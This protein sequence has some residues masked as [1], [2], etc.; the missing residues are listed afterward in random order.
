MKVCSKC[1]KELS[2][3]EFHKNKYSKDGHRSDCKS[4]H[5]Q[6]QR[7][8]YYKAKERNNMDYSKYKKLLFKQAWYYSRK[9]NLDF[10]DL[11]SESYLIFEEAKTLFDNTRNVTFS[12]YLTHR[13]RRLND[14][15]HKEKGILLKT[16]ELPRTVQYKEKEVELDAVSVLSENGRIL[17]SNILSGAFSQ[18]NPIRQKALVLGK[19]QKIAKEKLG[20]PVA[21]TEKVWEETRSWFRKVA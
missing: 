15:C 16:M 5:C 20:W 6:T 9:Y 21:T 4:C 8:Y 13:M 18:P 7:V 2:L 3:E 14:Y 11:L 19:A 1:K 17:I 12:T 10:G